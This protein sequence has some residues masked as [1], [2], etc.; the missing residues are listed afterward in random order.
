[1][2]AGAHSLSFGEGIQK[3]LELFKQC[4]RAT[5]AQALIH[6]FFGDRAVAK[7]PDVPKDTKAFSVRTVAIIGAGTMGGGIA[8]VFANAGIPVLL[9][10]TDQEAP[11]EEDTRPAYDTEMSHTRE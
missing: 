2:R 7:I 8:M 9:K 1:M 4:L 10:D 3:E 6:A 11:T 5:E